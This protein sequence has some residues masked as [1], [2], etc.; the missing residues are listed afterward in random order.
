MAFIDI[1]GF[2]EIIDESC[3]QPEIVSG[4]RALFGDIASVQNTILSD[5]HAITE[6]ERMFPKLKGKTIPTQA[7]AFSDTIVLSRVV[8]EETEKILSLISL[9]N[10]TSE[11]CSRLLEYGCLTRGAI[12]I[13][14]LFHEGNVIFGPA[15]VEAYRLE[16]KVAVFP[17][18]LFADDLIGYRDLISLHHIHQPAMLCDEDGRY[19]LNVLANHIG[20]AEMGLTRPDVLLHIRRILQQMRRNVL[21]EP[22]KSE[23]VEW[24]VRYFNRTIDSW[25]PQKFGL[26]QSVDKL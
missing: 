12:T 4:L 20:T 6:I 11:F 1:L 10:R 26:V 2:S 14:K 19:Y 16:S 22:H 3:R 9:I 15:L 8:R 23:K 24:Y 5:N 25:E 17:R 18:V 13:G 7:V 21:D